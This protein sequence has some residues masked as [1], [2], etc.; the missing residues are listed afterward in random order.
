MDVNFVFP[1]YLTFFTVFPF[2]ILRTSKK[3]RMHWLNSRYGAVELQGKI[4]QDKK[5]TIFV[6]FY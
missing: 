1:F 6:A 4:L 5:N 2:S 3:M